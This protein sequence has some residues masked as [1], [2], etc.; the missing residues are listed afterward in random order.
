MY[1]FFFSARLLQAAFFS[2][3]YSHAWMTK[4]ENDTS[5]FCMAVSISWINGIGK[6]IVLFSVSFLFDFIWKDILTYLFLCMANLY[7]NLQF[8]VFQLHVA[9][10]VFA[11]FKFFHVSRFSKC[12]VICLYGKSRNT[13]IVLCN[14]ARCAKCPSPSWVKGRGDEVGLPTLFF[15]RKDLVTLKRES[16]FL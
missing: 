12:I 14:C 9:E 6:R 8:R 5:W 2:S 4:L 10:D 16:V 7:I 3:A 13:G 11:V 15:Y 1:S